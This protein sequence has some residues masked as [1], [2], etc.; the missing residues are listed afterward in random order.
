[1]KTG[2]L[3]VVECLANV[4]E[5]LTRARH[6]SRVLSTLK[7]SGRSSIKGVTEHI[8]PTIT[9]AEDFTLATESRYSALLDQTAR[10]QER[11]YL[12]RRRGLWY[13]FQ[14]LRVV[15]IC[16]ILSRINWEPKLAVWSDSINISHAQYPWLERLP[17]VH[18]SNRIWWPVVTPLEIQTSILQQPAEVSHQMG[19]SKDQLS[20]P[21]ILVTGT[22]KYNNSTPSLEREC[23]PQM[24]KP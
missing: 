8:W 24:V 22:T 9:E 14:R 2:S 7:L 16:R 21:A 13:P 15:T 10:D 3:Q 17:L 5:D 11:R 18:H 12:S 19:P 20:N 4:L 23:R 6:L 1:M